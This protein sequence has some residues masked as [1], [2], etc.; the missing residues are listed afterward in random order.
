MY[1]PTHDRPLLSHAAIR[2][3]IRLI[4]D[5]RHG[6]FTLVEQ[7]VNNIPRYVIISYT[8]GANSKEVTFKDLIE[9]TGK[10]KAGYKKIEFCRK[11]AASDGL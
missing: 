7:N 11:Q 10:N 8:W 9:G 3:A 2:T 6:D 4:V 1:P 5:K